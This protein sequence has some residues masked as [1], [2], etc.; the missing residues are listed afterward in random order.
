MK[1]RTPLNTAA[2]SVVS[3][4]LKKQ[5]QENKILQLRIKKIQ[6][7]IRQEGVELDRGMHDSL[8]S[9]M[10]S[11]EIVNPLAK[12]FW[13]EQEKNF[14]RVNSGRRWH[15]MMIRLALLLHT[16]SPQAYRSLRET[17]VIALPGE[18]T[19]RDFTNYITPTQGFQPE[20]HLI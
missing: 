13:S 12:L 19:L 8:Q 17:G 9:I 1:P 16:E 2:K 10:S 14:G 5:R 15:P 7:T 6:K 18:S 11:K 3:E 20:V 4:A